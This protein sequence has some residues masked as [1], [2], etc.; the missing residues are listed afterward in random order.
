MLPLGGSLA[1]SSNIVV[2]LII[3]SSELCWCSCLKI[4]GPFQ[5]KQ[6]KTKHFLLIWRNRKAFPDFLLGKAWMGVCVYIYRGICMKI[7]RGARPAP[8][9]PQCP[10][11]SPCCKTAESLALLPSLGH[12]GFPCLHPGSAWDCLG[13]TPRILHLQHPRAVSSPATP[14]GCALDLA[15]LPLPTHGTC[16]GA[17]D[18]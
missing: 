17:G 3:F 7:F 16:C 4:I 8:A 13:G 15:S 11:W 12:Q 1:L 6:Q 9:R 2:T 10:H 14:R 18:V 5:G